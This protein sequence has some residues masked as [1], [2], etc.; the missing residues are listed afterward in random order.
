M[1][2][3]ELVEMVKDYLCPSAPPRPLS[4]QIFQTLHH[5]TTRISRSQRQVTMPWC[6][7]KGVWRV[8]SLKGKSVAK[9]Q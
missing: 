7:G 1:W 9:I 5:L 6:F 4:T 3:P 2:F 8:A